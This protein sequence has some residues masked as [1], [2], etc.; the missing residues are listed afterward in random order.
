MMTRKLYS[1]KHCL[2]RVLSFYPEV[3]HKI[4]L[5]T[6][7]LYKLLSFNLEVKKKMVLCTNFLY[8]VLS[9]NQ[10]VKQQE[11]TMYKLS[12]QYYTKFK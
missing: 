3:K 4:V 7:F 8:R 5:C 2:Y 1:S 6:N 11:S 12:V 9:F 10:E